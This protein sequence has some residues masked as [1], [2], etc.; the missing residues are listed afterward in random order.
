[1]NPSRFTVVGVVAAS[2]SLLPFCGAA[3]R[4]KVG[5]LDLKILYVGHP[6]TPREAD[7]VQFL[8]QHF[9]EVRTGDLKRFDGTRTEQSDVIILDYDGKGFNAPCP[10]LREDYARSTVTVGVAGAHIC[11]NRGLKSG[12]L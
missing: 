9:K 2:L 3:E 8:R 6:D 7:F 5:K 12:Y 1:M 4:D 11:D 10:R